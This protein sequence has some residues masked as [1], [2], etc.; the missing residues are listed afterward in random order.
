M[1]CGVQLERVAEG[2]AS[3]QI[4]PGCDGKR[5]ERVLRLSDIC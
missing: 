1:D 3:V 5:L 4:L 2:S